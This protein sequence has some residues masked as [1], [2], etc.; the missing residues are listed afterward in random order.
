MG[1]SSYGVHKIGDVADSILQQ[2]ADPFGRL[3]EQLHRQSQLYILRQHEY[4]HA[5]MVLPD[6][7][8]RSHAFIR[9]GR[10]Q[11][12]VDDRDIRGQA[13]YT[14]QEV[15]GVVV[16]GHDVESRAAQDSGDASRSSTLS[17]AIATSREA[18]DT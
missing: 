14:H 9:V 6:V 12:D 8:R 2:V 17:S 7:Q 1:N 15:V 11:P 5:A 13:S 10:W 3:R 4:R 16:R 18:T